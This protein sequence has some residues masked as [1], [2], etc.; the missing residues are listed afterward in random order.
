MCCE[1][2]ERRV[3]LGAVHLYKTSKQMAPWLLKEVGPKAPPGM[4]EPRLD[5]GLPHDLPVTVPSSLWGLR[6]NVTYSEKPSL[7]TTLK[8]PPCFSLPEWFPNLSAAG[9]YLEASKHTD[10]CVSPTEI[11]I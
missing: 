8:Q 9:D 10:T 7:T 4:Q 2:T 1:A 11:M 5:K 6:S 3:R